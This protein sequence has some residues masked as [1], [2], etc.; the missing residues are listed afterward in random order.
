V[1]FSKEQIMKAAKGLTAHEMARIATHH[2]RGVNWVGCSKGHIA[3]L[4]SS[5]Q[6][7]RI[8]VT[9]F[10][11]ALADVPRRD[12]KKEREEKKVKAERDLKQR[13]AYITRGRE[14]ENRFEKIGL[15]VWSTAQGIGMSHDV[16]TEIL[17]H[18]E[19]DS[20]YVQSMNEFVAKK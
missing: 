18:L 7:H 5:G 14:L 19:N 16:A 2:S 11:R 3:E 6:D 15:S 20:A 8:N 13:T 1:K 4:I 9:T 10:L 17:E 12:R